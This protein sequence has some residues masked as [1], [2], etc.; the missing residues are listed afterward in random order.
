[1]GVLC[2]AHTYRYSIDVN[3]NM[4]EKE[5]WPH[6]CAGVHTA[7]MEIFTALCILHYSQEYCIMY[8]ITVQRLTVYTWCSLFV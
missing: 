6:L 4:I 8:R 3:K 1:M 2:E 7:G 5:D